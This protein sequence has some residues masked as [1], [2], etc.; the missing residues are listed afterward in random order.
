MIV[1]IAYQQRAAETR[2]RRIHRWIPVEASTYLDEQNGEPMAA[3]NG[4][5]SPRATRKHIVNHLT[6]NA[7]DGG[8]ENQLE[9][10]ETGIVCEE[11]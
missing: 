7:D 10:S 2:R 1:I 3:V 5:S 8:E 11:K 4:Q 9:Q 6:G